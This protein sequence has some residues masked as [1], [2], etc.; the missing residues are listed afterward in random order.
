MSSWGWRD[1]SLSWAEML[2]QSQGVDF[3][4]LQ[5][6]SKLVG[7]W[8]EES[9]IIPLTLSRGVWVMDPQD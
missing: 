1:I 7:G 2:T 3:K 5:E 6:S 4:L 9:G 8:V